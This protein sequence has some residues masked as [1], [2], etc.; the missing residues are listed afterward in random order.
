MP[1]TQPED[2]LIQTRDLPWASLGEGVW[3]KIL[4][5]SEETGFWSSLIRMEP[6]SQFAPHKHFGAADFFVLKGRL[7]YRAGEA[8]E[9]CYGYEPLG[10]VHDETTAPE[11]T[12]IVFNSF[13]P[14][15][16][17]NSDGSIA[18]L[19]N[20]E[21]ARELAAGSEGHYTAATDKPAA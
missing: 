5:V 6:G 14:I 7:I 1:A 20:Y 13:G 10:V 8:T 11:E 16:F 18:Q 4:R 12:V 19:L 2:L 21:T 17:Y 3:I 9:G 15:V